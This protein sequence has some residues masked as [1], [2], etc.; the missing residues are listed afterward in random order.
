MIKAFI[1]FDKFKS[2][3]IITAEYLSVFS[4]VR[5]KNLVI[6]YYSIRCKLLV[7]SLVV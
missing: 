1:I 6:K 7:E 4:L 5:F 2:I 3:N